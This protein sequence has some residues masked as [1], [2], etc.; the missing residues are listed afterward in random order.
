M[1]V[2]TM[3]NCDFNHI[4]S[5]CEEFA[6]SYGV[7][8]PDKALGSCHAAVLAFIRKYEESGCR[9]LHVCG[10]RTRHPR[11][12]SYYTNYAD[13][14]PRF[15]HVMCILPN[16]MIVDFTNRQLDSSGDVCKFY[17]QNEL[18]SEWMVLSN[19]WEKLDRLFTVSCSI[20]QSNIHRTRECYRPI[21]E[22]ELVEKHNKNIMVAKQEFGLVLSC[23]E[24]GVLKLT[25]TVE[26]NDYL[27]YINLEWPSIIGDICHIPI[28]DE[29]VVLIT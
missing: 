10:Y 7:T 8:T 25:G 23:I 16:R 29:S 5:L 17:T 28:E 9:E 6:V 22:E 4:K 19:E 14:D 18:E 15:Y 12:H 26:N 1:K 2:E 3:E 21:T 20:T 13:P 24:L 11:R 27:R